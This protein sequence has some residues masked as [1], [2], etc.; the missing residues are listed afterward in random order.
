MCCDVYFQVNCNEN[1]LPGTVLLPDI[2]L[3]VCCSSVHLVSELVMY[4]RYLFGIG[5]GME[6]HTGLF[7][8]LEKD[9]GALEV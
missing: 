9:L 3:L 2:P 7:I 4:E 8:A 1:L 6:H 5:A